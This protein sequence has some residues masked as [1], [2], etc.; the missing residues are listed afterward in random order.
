VAATAF[1]TS[2]RMY[3]Y[4]TSLTLANPSA[5]KE[6]WRFEMKRVQTRFCIDVAFM[7]L[8]VFP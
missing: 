7:Y 5:P 3:R 2:F 4:G 8:H 6:E 1:F